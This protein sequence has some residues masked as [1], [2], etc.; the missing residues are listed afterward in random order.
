MDELAAAVSETVLA[1][2]EVFAERLGVRR[3]GGIALLLDD[4]FHAVGNVELY[5]KKALTIAEHPPIEVGKTFVL[6]ASSERLSLENIGRHLWANIKT[7]WNLDRGGFRELM[8]QIEG[9]EAERRWQATGGNPRAVELLRD[10]S[11][12]EEA[13]VE[14]MYK[15]GN[16]DIKLLSK[17]KE[18]VEKAVED[19]GA[20]LEA[21]EEVKRHLIA[22]NLILKIMD[23]I[24]PL[25]KDK[26]LG[27]G[28]EYAWQTPY[29]AELWRWR[30]SG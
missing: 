13:V 30:S 18:A 22:K 15:A 29:T 8:S 5:A 3:A 28:R 25:E 24:A 21:P 7:L 12:S 10:E 2:G 9:V 14:K 19:P 20:L 4:V 17:Y 16:V 26:M 11:W 27:V 1:L 6:I 23:P